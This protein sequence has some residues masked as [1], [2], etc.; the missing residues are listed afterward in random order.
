VELKK[1][2]RILVRRRNLFFSIFGGIILLSLILGFSFTPIYTA[3]SK[4]LVKNIDTN[5][6]LVSSLPT[7]AGKIQYIESANALGNM[8]A[9]I[10]NEDSINKVIKELNLTIRGVPIACKA[11]LNPGTFSLLRN[12]RGVKVK[13]INNTEIFEIIGYSP[14]PSEAEDI[15]NTVVANFLRL[16]KRINRRAASGVV[17]FLQR[18]TKKIKESIRYFENAIKDY[19]V[20]HEAV[21]L[22]NKSRELVSQLVSLEASLAR[23][24][25]EKERAHPE[26]V[27][28]MRQISVMRDELLKIPEIQVNF[29]TAQ[30]V[31][32]SMVDMYKS[33]MSDL[34]KAKVLKA[35]NVTNVSVL[36]HA[37]ISPIHKKYNIYFPKKKLMLLVGILLGGSISIFVVFLMEYL[38][39]TIKEPQDVH[40]ILDQKLL[41]VLPKTRQPIPIHSLPQQFMGKVANIMLSIKFVARGTLPKFLTI[42]SFGWEEG[43]TML[44]SYLGY[45]I[46]ESGQKTL[47]VDINTPEGSRVHRYF[48]T[49]PPAI[50]LVDYL[51]SNR[52]FEDVVKKLKGDN[53]FLLSAARNFSTETGISLNSKKIQEFFH[54]IQP[55]YDV[56]IYDAPSF[57]DGFEYILATYGLDNVIMVVETNRFSGELLHT[58]IESLKGKGITLL[59]TVLTKH[60]SN[61]RLPDLS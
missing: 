32:D 15:A 49:P 48:D 27:A 5:T 1:Y 52:N 13:Q 51:Q 43:K 37:Q 46:A 22:E 40:E 20:S 45:L 14:D 23:M 26:V 33:L 31:A 57:S 61:Y 21:S 42:T 8:K 36:E 3:T 35:M 58:E 39:D 38:D 34:E 7:N 53:L 50:G 19:Q 24:L 25:S 2:W 60:P 18:E 17:S 44:S 29:N 4:V 54:A 55:K 30:R 28:T 10:E 56:I 11:F 59:G 6:T 41:G 47:L 9:L 16:N 12:K